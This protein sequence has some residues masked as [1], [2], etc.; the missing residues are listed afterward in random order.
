[1]GFE[2]KIRF[3]SCD[4]SLIRWRFDLRDGCAANLMFAL[5]DGASDIW[6]ECAS[7][8][9]G[10]RAV[11]LLSSPRAH[12]HTLRSPASWSINWCRLCIAV[13]LTNV[14]ATVALYS[15]GS[16][17]CDAAGFDKLQ[18]NGNNFHA[19]K[20]PNANG[21]QTEKCLPPSCCLCLRLASGFSTCW[22]TIWRHDWALSALPRIEAALAEAWQQHL[23]EC[24]TLL[25]P[26]QQQHQLVHNGGIYDN[27]RAIRE[28]AKTVEAANDA[29]PWRM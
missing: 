9:M 25:W 20:T 3:D 22:Q 24:L 26:Q 19:G 4:L 10:H 14:A 18:L 11:H 8:Q 2:L 27:L 1:M 29:M 15:C 23:T 6:S 16:W 12:T 7:A 5:N 21:N 28:G 17:R 13:K